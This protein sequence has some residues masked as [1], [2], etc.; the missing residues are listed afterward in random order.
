MA[1]LLSQQPARL[2]TDKLVYWCSTGLVCAVM[3]FSV[4][5]FVFNDHFPFPNGSEG[6]FTHLGLPRYFKVE[7]SIAK[8]LGLVALLVPSV[9]FK[10]KELAYFGFGITLVSACI[11]HASVGDHKLG[12]Y[13]L[14]DP[15][16]FLVILLIS[17]KYFLRMGRRQ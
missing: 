11:A 15:L 3:A 2:R 6:A 17:Y 10:L 14:L 7:L 1:A 5:N 13:Y 9:P 16:L 12:F 4:F 8:T